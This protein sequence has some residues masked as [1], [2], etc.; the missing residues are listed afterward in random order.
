MA[1]RRRN[2]K[3]F[4]DSSVLFTAVN[5]PIGGS[6]KLFTF[7]DIKLIVSNI[8][9]QEVEKNVR[10]KLHDYH[11]DRFFMLV[12][13][14][15]IID[16]IP[17]DEQILKARKVIVEKDAVILAE[18]K[19]SDCD[20]LITLDKKDFLQEKVFDFIKPKKILT[21]KMFFETQKL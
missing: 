12:D 9:L 2:L 10:T 21:P 8:V 19:D 13:K 6:A 15:S 3:L 1:T 20:Y 4:L 7:T 16:Q 11:L 5:S 17:N 18:A 14:L